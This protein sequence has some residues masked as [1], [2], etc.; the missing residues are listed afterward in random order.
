MLNLLLLRRDIKNSC[1]VGIAFLT[2][3]DEIR[4]PSYTC[5]SSYILSGCPSSMPLAAYK[6]TTVSD[7]ILVRYTSVSNESTSLPSLIIERIILVQSAHFSIR[8]SL[9]TSFLID[10]RYS[11]STSISKIFR[12]LSEPCLS[13]NTTP[14]SVRT[15]GTYSPSAPLGES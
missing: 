4:P 5:P 6:P 12:M 9:R 14:P 15:R 8:L 1:N 2:L 7:T 3:P 11:S 13:W 10:G